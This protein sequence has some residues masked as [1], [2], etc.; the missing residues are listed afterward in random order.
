[1]FQNCGEDVLNSMGASEPSAFIQISFNAAFFLFL[2]CSP[3]CLQG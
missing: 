2:G 1:M 3:T